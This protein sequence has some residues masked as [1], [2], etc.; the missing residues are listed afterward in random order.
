MQLDCMGKIRP[1]PRALAALVFALSLAAGQQMAGLHALAHAVQ[2]LHGH[3]DGAPA[4]TGH[5]PNHGAFADLSSFLP[6]SASPA[7][8]PAAS[9]ASPLGACLAIEPRTPNL[10]F[11]SRA[12]PD[13]PA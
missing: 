7:L 8:A 1:W 5:C 4:G 11:R 10:A 9:P 3:E 2:D 12:P 6:A 13:L